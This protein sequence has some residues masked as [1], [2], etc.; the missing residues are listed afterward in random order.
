MCL[1]QC[2]VENELHKE[3]TKLPV[4]VGSPED[5]QHAHKYEMKIENENDT[6]AAA[7]ATPTRE[8]R[9]RSEVT[10]TIKQKK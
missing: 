6:G 3:I 9:K 8:S 7:M 4:F 2:E 1:R 10:K 5:S